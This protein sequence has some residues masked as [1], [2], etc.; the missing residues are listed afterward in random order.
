MSQWP[1]DQP[2]NC[3]AI[4]LR[5]IIAGEEPILHVTHDE[6]DHGWQF[7][8]PSDA[9]VDDGVV[10]SL[11]EIL[12]MD[13]TIREVA[14]LPPDWPAWRRAIGKPWVRE[15]NPHGEPGT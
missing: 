6:D 15:I 3:A 8:G 10:V 2:R 4:S 7:L 9:K 1:F 13:P 14:D 5:Q 12:E 11:A